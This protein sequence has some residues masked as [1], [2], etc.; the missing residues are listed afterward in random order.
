MMMMRRSWIE[1]RLHCRA[2]FST[3]SPEVIQ[4][5]GLQD[6]SHRLDRP[7]D[8]PSWCSECCS[9]AMLTSD[10]AGSPQGSKPGHSGFAKPA[11]TKLCLLLSACKLNPNL[12][13]TARHR[14]AFGTIFN[15]HLARVCLNLLRH[16]LRRSPSDQ[17]GK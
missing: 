10:D 12:K 2:T 3:G 6:A 16:Y 5:P 1:G 14:V 17:G 13:K 8:P 15:M 11:R 4:D 7:R 9:V